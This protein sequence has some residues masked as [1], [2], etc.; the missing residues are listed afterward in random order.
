MNNFVIAQIFGILGI[1]AGILSMQ[2]KNRKQILI[3]L[4]LLNTFCSLNFVFLSNMTSAYICFF[5]N[6]EMIINYCFEI[7]KRD[8]PRWIIGI[9]IVINIILGMITFKN[10]VD[11]MPIVCAILYCGT[12]LSK[13]ESN[14]RKLMFFNQTLWLIFDFVVGAYASCINA[15]LTIVSVVIAMFRYDFNK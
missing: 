10:I 9:Y 11:I 6:I 2:F 1:I 15:F 13:N 14:I 3:A 5:A 4:F 8:V 7:R 12:I